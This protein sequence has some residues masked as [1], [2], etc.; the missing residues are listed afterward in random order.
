MIAGE[1]GGRRGLLFIAALLALQL[2]L[3]VASFGP[4]LQVSIFCTGPR[5]STLAGVFGLVHLLF[6]GL[7][8]MGTL[9]LRFSSLRVPYAALLILGLAALPLQANFVSNGQLKCDLP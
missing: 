9:S 7:L 1:I 4:L 8:F 2:L 3:L 5:S 6:L